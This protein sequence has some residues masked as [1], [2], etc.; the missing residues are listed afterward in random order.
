MFSIRL[1]EF[2][3]KWYR[4]FTGTPI[5]GSYLKSGIALSD[6]LIDL[7]K[8]LQCVGLVQSFDQAKFGLSKPGAK[9]GTLVRLL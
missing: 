6:V 2:G 9:S 4:D 8:P 7:L 5:H 1:R 3:I